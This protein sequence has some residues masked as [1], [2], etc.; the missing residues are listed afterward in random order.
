MEL[1]VLSAYKAGLNM[2]IHI[3]HTHITYTYLIHIN[4]SE[5]FV[6]AVKC[7]RIQNDLFRKQ[8]PKAL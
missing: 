8:Q 3:I 5:Y 1:T 2:C 4:L 7:K 6:G